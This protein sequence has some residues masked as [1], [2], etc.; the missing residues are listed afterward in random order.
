[1]CI[2]TCKNKCQNCMS[3]FKRK[4][5]AC[6]SVCKKIFKTACGPVLDYILYYFDLA[7][8][9]IF[10]VTMVS[11]CHFRVQIR[12]ETFLFS[13]TYYIDFYLKRMSQRCY[14]F[15]HQ[16]ILK[17]MPLWKYDGW[18]PFKGVKTHFGKIPLKRCIFSNKIFHFHPY[19][20]SNNYCSD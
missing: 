20:P 17:K 18:F 12:F 1:M 6:M 13:Y 8:D 4:C 2:G 5:P 7:S 10:A 19:C 9:T 3:G 14:Q 16:R 11:N 15:F